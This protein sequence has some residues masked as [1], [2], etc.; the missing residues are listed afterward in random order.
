MLRFIS[1][2][3]LQTLSYLWTQ[4]TP[5]SVFCL[6][7][8]AR[9]LLWNSSCTDQKGYNF[10]SI[11]QSRKLNIVNVPKADLDFVP[12]GTSF[13]DITVAGDRVNVTRWIF[14]EL[15][16]LSDHPYIYFEVPLSPPT[17][18]RSPK[19]RNSVL[20]RKSISH[21]TIV[22]DSESRHDSC[23]ILLILQSRFPLTFC[24]FLVNWLFPSESDWFWLI[25]GD[26][27]WFLTT[28]S[29]FLTS[30]FVIFPSDYF[31][32]LSDSNWFWA[33]YED[34]TQLRPPRKEYC[35]DWFFCCGNDEWRSDSE[36]LSQLYWI[37][38]PGHYVTRYLLP[39]RAT[40]LKNKEK[41][42]P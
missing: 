28:S 3:P 39:A 29:K 20:G 1:A 23:L 34:C 35:T 25:L 17:P 12:R 31:V 33:R 40:V 4:S 37:V 21:F 22:R 16:S 36:T 19:A 13:V 6:D 7:A 27:R 11:F 15:H 2:D 41:L 10:E 24:T 32:I 42:L 9:N 30:K 38:L 18:L 14:L 5:S 26:F 8:N